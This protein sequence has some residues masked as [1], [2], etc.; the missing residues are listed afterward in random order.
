MS[1]HFRSLKY[2]IVLPVA[3]FM[4][5]NPSPATQTFSPA[6]ALKAFL[7]NAHA[8]LTIITVGIFTVWQL[9]K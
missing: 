8:S 4:A 5:T 7:G 6:W 1:R 3:D 2:L 9:T